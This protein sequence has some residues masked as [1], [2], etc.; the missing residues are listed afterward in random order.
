MAH[1]VPPASV[2]ASMSVEAPASVEPLVHTTEEA[3]PIPGEVERRVE[4]R[5]LEE[6]GRSLELSPTQQLAQI[7]TE[8]GPSMLG[9]EELAR[10]KLQ[11]IMGGKA[12]RKEFL[13]ARK[14]KEA[15]EVPAR[16]S[17]SL[18]DLPVSEEY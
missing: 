11:L 8:A 16:N 5:R 15:L 7:A 4:V 18:Q 10:K 9:W 6:V 1:T 2:E 3:P 13:K 17:G 12:P 14:L